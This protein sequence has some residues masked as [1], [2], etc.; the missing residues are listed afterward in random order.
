[1]APGRRTRTGLALVALGLATAGALRAEP[2]TLDAAAEMVAAAALPRDCPLDGPRD[3]PVSFRYRVDGACHRADVAAALPLGAAAV[4]RWLLQPAAFP[5]WALLDPRGAA[6]LRDVRFDAESG[7]GSV[8]IGSESWLG[9]PTRNRR[10]R[11]AGGGPPL[12]P[13]RTVSAI[14]ELTIDG[15]PPAADTRL[16]GVRHRTPRVE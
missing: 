9:R 5:E 14:T 6:N 2:G 12:S 13:D 8:T 4:S 1:M 3:V 11:A 16:D 10:R 15:T 7:A